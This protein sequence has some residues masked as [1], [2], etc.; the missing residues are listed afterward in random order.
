M[1]I[2]RTAC[3]FGRGHLTFFQVGGPLITHMHTLSWHMT[4]TP[5]CSP[6]KISIWL[7]SFP[8]HI[9]TQYHIPKSTFNDWCDKLTPII[10]QCHDDDDKKQAIQHAITSTRAG[11]PRLLDTTTEDQLVNWAFKMQQTGYPVSKLTLCMKAMELHMYAQQQQYNDTTG[12][13]TCVTQV[14]R[15]FD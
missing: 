6:I 1:L 12:D 4:Q 9:C 3:L 13:I 14:T 7:S 8:F 10:T 2:V 5:R 15:F 11:P